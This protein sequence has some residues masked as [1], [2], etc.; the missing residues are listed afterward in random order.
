MSAA[1]WDQEFFRRRL[2]GQQET[3]D[4]QEPPAAAPLAAERATIAE[5]LLA[6]AGD[7]NAALLFEDQRW[8]WR[9]LVQEAPLCAER[10]WSASTRPGGERS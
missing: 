7:D 2:A 3:G 4:S 5:L 10:R 8:S 9:E 6:R 1:V